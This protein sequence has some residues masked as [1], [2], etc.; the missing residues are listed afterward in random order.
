MVPLLA[1]FHDADDRSW[2]VV[3]LG[4]TSDFTR[5]TARAH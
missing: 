4:P 1:R 3:V 5:A 2:A